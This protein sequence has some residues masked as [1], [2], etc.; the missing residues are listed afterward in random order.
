MYLSVPAAY[1]MYLYLIV[2]LVF[3]LRSLFFYY[4]DK[5]MVFPSLLG[6][7]EKLIVTT[8]ISDNCTDGGWPIT[9][10]LWL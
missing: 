10:L 1:V 4:R 2:I 5:Y 7:E 9:R 3:V 6:D 8:Q